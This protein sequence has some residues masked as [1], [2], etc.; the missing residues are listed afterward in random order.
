LEGRKKEKEEGHQKKTRVIEKEI[1]G[2]II[3]PFPQLFV[4]GFLMETPPLRTGEEGVELLL[5]GGYQVETLPQSIT[6]PRNDKQQEIDACGE[7]PSLGWTNKSGGH[8]ISLPLLVGGKVSGG[9]R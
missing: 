2:W 4:V 7:H 6:M 8:F 3:R 1:V 9:E 5:T